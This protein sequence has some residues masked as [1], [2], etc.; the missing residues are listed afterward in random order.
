MGAG[1]ATLDS[2][3]LGVGVMVGLLI[4]VGLTEGVIVGVTIG[5]GVGVGVVGMVI[6]DATTSP[7]EAPLLFQVARRVAYPLAWA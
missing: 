1:V 5:D 6:V 3:S 4:E 7:I 2:E